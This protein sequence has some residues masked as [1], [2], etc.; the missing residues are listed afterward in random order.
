MANSEDGIDPQPQVEMAF[1][2]YWVYLSITPF[3]LGLLA[4][5][6]GIAGLF[7][8]SGGLAL[9]GAGIASALAGHFRR[10]GRSYAGWVVL[11]VLCLAGA[12]W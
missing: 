5:P 9:C 8:T 4:L 10:S 11:A 7:I 12:C 6:M 2:W 1:P 3:A